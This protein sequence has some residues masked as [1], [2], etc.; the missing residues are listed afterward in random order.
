MWLV[1][2]MYIYARSCKSQESMH[3]NMKQTLECMALFI[4]ST[5]LNELMCLYFQSR[6]VLLVWAVLCIWILL[7]ASLV[8][9]S[10]TQAELA[11][12][13]QV[14]RNNTLYAENLLLAT[15][16]VKVNDTHLLLCEIRSRLLPHRNKAQQH[17]MLRTGSCP[18]I[19]RPHVETPAFILLETAPDRAFRANTQV[20][21]MFGF[22]VE[23]LQRTLRII[24][25]PL[26]D[27]R[28]FAELREKGFQ[29][30]ESVGN[31]TFYNRTGDAMACQVQVSSVMIG[32]GRAV[33]VV[34][35]GA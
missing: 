22:H 18:A 29:G 33:S 16:M 11:L 31:I 20:S 27:V 15:R 9:A 24:C 13:E 34:I 25:G 26:T 3:A 17:S 35:E 4:V 21:D 32:E 5:G 1:V 28:K 8:A 14:K 2:E 10:L 23:Q 6:F 30:C 7:D 12:T 19:P